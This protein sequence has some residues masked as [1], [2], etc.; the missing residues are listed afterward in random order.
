MQGQAPESGKNII[1]E[2]ISDCDMVL[3]ARIGIL[4]WRLLEKQQIRPNVDHAFP[5]G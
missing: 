1:I 2:T 3:C 5:A 4:P